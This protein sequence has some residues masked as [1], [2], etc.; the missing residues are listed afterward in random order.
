MHTVRV[1]RKTYEE[2]V[3]YVVILLVIQFI[4]LCIMYNPQS[5]YPLHP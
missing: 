1:N 4:N 3:I 2:R 5:F